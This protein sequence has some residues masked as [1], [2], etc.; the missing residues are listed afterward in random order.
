MQSQLY[1]RT[2]PILLPYYLRLVY[3][4]L[5]E[6]GCTRE[7][8]FGNQTLTAEQLHDE[9]YRLSIEQHEHFILHALDISNDPHLAIRVTQMQDP[10][11][12]NLALLAAANSGKI[13][14]ALHMI[15]RYSS[16]FT[17]VFSI[18]SLETDEHAVMDIESHLEHNSVIYFSITAFV[19]FLDD[20]F[21]D[22]LQGQHLLKRVEL[23]TPR[24]A[25]FDQ[26]RDEF[27]FP[28]EFDCP[29]NRIYFNRQFLD[30]PLKQA[31][32][33]TVRLLTEMSDRQLAEAE[34]EMTLVGAVKAI[35]IDQIA[36][37]PKLDE[38]AKQLGLSSRSLRRKLAESGTSYKKVLDAIRMKMATKLLKDTDAPVASIAYELGFGNASDFGRAFKRCNGV[39]PSAVRA[40]KAP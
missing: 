40:D 19:L 36:T 34:A 3:L 25:G 4:A 8:I 2:E 1:S 17:R 31:D 24:P 22:V 18:S 7:Q 29:H 15:M 14:R 5:L 26:V 6:L 10:L 39:S 12:T 11:K 23:I 13:S 16:I 38:V 28:L 35:L 21:A 33:Q 32:P 27:P 20:F 9:H 37:P 30:Q